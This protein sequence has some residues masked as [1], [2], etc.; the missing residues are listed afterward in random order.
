[1]I[2]DKEVHSDTYERMKMRNNE[3]GDNGLVP[4]GISTLHSKLF[5]RYF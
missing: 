2:I 1:M 5:L 4:V 3:S